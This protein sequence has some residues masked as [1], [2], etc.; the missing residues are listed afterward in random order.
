[1]AQYPFPED[2]FA[3][4]RMDWC[5]SMPLEPGGAVAQVI[6]SDLARQCGSFT[7]ATHDR[8]RIARTAPQLQELLKSAEIEEWRGKCPVVQAEGV[9]GLGGAKS[10]EGQLWGAFGQPRQDATYR[11]IAGLQEE[12]EEEGAAE[13]AQQAV[14]AAAPE[15][16][17]EQQLAVDMARRNAAPRR[18][19]N[20]ANL[21][22]LPFLS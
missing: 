16:H 2:L 9:C 6:C 19:V 22:G 20:G 15:L 13:A 7:N 18:V 10:F 17:P 14:F 11:K 5:R 21:L 8:A 3:V 1:M 12:E 4:A